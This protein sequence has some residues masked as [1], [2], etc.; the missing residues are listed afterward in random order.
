MG[1]ALLALG[2]MTQA[3]EHYQNALQIRL[4]LEE[5]GLAA[6]TCAGLVRIAQ[7]RGDTSNMEQHL[8]MILNYL[9]TA[10][11]DG[12]SEPARIYLTCYNALKQLGDSRAKT[13]LDAGQ[14]FIQ[15]RAKTISDPAKQQSYL[16]RVR[17]NAELMSTWEA[18]RM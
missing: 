5:N 9:Q 4:D 8:E 11:L 15:A 12:T 3:E 16:H 17:A 2:Q 13:L 14:Q 18:Q 6:E 10:S 1:H 7:T